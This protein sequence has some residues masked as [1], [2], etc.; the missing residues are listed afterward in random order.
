ITASEARP[1]VEKY[2]GR[3]PKVPVPAHHWEKEPPQNVAR[4]I[5]MHHPNVRQPVWSRFYAVPS[6]AYGKT[7]ETM[8][9]F[10]LQE[11]LGDGKGSRLYQSLVVEQKLASNVEVDYSGFTI[12]PSNFDISVVPESNVSMEALEKAVDKELRRAMTEPFTEKEMARAKS[13][14]KAE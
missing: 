12:G 2:Y 7:E 1:L 3:L 11:I 14:L 4:R 9:I 10:V 5:V 6:V 13:L 8:P